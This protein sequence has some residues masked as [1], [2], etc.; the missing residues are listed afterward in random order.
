ML[1]AAASAGPPR[2]K[3]RM[4]DRK[5]ASLVTSPSMWTRSATPGDVVTAQRARPL[6]RIII[7]PA[8]CLHRFSTASAVDNWA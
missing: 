3:A 5:C 4:P 2:A 6:I 8:D 1:R 7:E